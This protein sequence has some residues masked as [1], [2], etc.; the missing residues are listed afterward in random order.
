MAGLK[1]ELDER[2]KQKLM[3]YLA[4]KISRRFLRGGFELAMNHRFLIT[5]VY[6]VSHIL[7]DF[8]PYQDP[9]LVQGCLF[10]DPWTG[11]GNCPV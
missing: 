3:E 9:A 8:S 11:P 6:L 10:D 4:E 5:T 1:L 7:V 2:A